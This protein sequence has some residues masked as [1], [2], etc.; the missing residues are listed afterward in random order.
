[1][2]K[3]VMILFMVLAVCGI[4]RAEL[5]SDNRGFEAGD[6]TDW[7]QWGSGGAPWQ[8]WYDTFTVI[9]DPCNPAYEGDYYL[10]L[11]QGGPGNTWGYNVAWQGE[12]P[13]Y[14]IPG[15]PCENYTLS[16]WVRSNDTGTAVVKFEAS[17][18][19][20]V[21]NKWEQEINVAFVADGTWQHVS[22]DFVSPAGTAWLRAVVG[23]NTNAF[24]IDIDAV[25]LVPEP[26]SIVLF[27]LGSAFVLRRRRKA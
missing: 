8:S 19:D 6:T 24:T 4:T 20:W 5:L 10:E 27:G 11:S 1:M 25:S 3:K 12:D 23:S 21:N 7:M 22:A 16:Y 9:S 13:C 26:M 2:M 18:G 15:D 14:L 17:D